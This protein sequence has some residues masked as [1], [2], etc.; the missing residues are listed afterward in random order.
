M[1]FRSLAAPAR[2]FSI[3]VSAAAILLSRDLPMCAQSQGQHVVPTST[4][5]LPAAIQTKLDN[6]GAALKTAQAGGDAKAEAAALNGIG[7]VYFNISEFDKALD[8]Y[9][10]ALTQARAVKDPIQEAAALNGIAGCYRLQNQIA[11]SVQT[12]TEVLNVTKASRDW[13]GQNTAFDGIGWLDI[14]I[15][16]WK[17]ALQTF[18]KNVEL[19]RG[20]GEKELEASAL[21][22]VGIASASLGSLQ[23]A[24]QNAELSIELY[25]DIGDAEG[26]ANGYFALATGYEKL[27][28]H[29]KALQLGNLALASFRES[30]DRRRQCAVL[31][32]LAVIYMGLFQPPK[33]LESLNQA[34]SIAREDGDRA[35]EIMAL[36]GL[37]MLSSATGENKKA[38]ELYTQSLAIARTLGNE[39]SEAN[40]LNLVGNAYETIA[41][42]QKALDNFN[43]AL[44]LYKHQ[45]DLTGEANV[46][47]NIANAYGVLGEPEKSLD[48]YNQAS[49]LF[50]QLN[51]SAGVALVLQ[52]IGWVHM[53][54][55][56]NAKALDNFTRALALFRAQESKYRMT[57][58]L[59]N[60][61]FAHG[62]LNE[63]EKALQPLNEALDLEKELGDRSTEPYTL[64][65]L[66][67][68]YAALGERQKAL[69]ALNQ[70]LPMGRHADQIDTEV[71]TLDKIGAVYNDMGQTAKAQEYL[72]EALP[73]AAEGGNP[74]LQS[75]VL[76]DLML[77]LEKTQPAMAIFYGKLG[78]NQL[79]KMRSS[80][81]GLDKG[82]QGSF[83]VSREDCYHDLADLLIAQGRLPEAQQVLNLLKEQ[84][85]SDYT[86]GDAAN[87]LSPLSLTPAEKQAEDD[88]QKSTERIVGLGEE[89][90]DLRKIT[91]RTPEQD[92]RYKVVSAQI[93]TANASLSD[94][95]NNRLYKLFSA[96]GDANK[97][98]ADVKGQV[99][100]LNQAL[101]KM[102]H[103]VA[104]YTLV[105]KDRTSIIVITR[106]TEVARESVITEA[107][108]NKRIAAFEQVLRKPSSDPKPAAQELYDILIGPV[109]KDLDQAHAETLVWS[110]DGALRYV[111]MAALYDGQHYLVE[112][113]NTVTI[114]PVSIPHLT[115]KPDVS[116]LSVAAMGISRKYEANLPELKAVVGELDDVANDPQVNGAKGALPGTILLDNRFTEQAMEDQLG[117]QP[118][119]VH[120][121]SHFVFNPGDD[122]QSYLLL[123][124]K[125][126]S[127]KGFHL[128]VADFHNKP[129]LTLKGTE[130]LT[131][132]ACETGMSGTTSDGREVDG[133]GTTA[134]SKGAKAVIST[135]WEVDDAST[136]ELMADFY[137]RWAGGG[138][139][140]E[141]VEALRQAQLDLLLGRADLKATE[142]QDT[143]NRGLAPDVPNEPGPQGFAH[144]Y[145]WAPFVLMGNWR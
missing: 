79:Q 89:W 130:L 8:N 39:E 132:S 16:D 98:L 114:T 52:N 108:L 12:Y 99:D 72:K 77:S 82:L 137:R 138:G 55:G 36:N 95:Y 14:D 20:Q 49:P 122:K 42:G 2:I 131:L 92:A 100:D 113:Y 28:M 111:P 22:G 66:G 3:A 57:N 83:V 54:L 21:L 139:K 47:N 133:L 15:A 7:S 67:Y 121:A 80:I 105:G 136:G 144:P 117:S 127:G 44:T 118:T 18:Q 128:T 123:A 74:L 65:V 102:P 26:E 5:P 70:A 71:F 140:V 87:T 9:N 104:L 125:D 31:G 27:R 119:V 142:H 93:E 50:Q 86:R 6:F 97:Q 141:K 84:E 69:D 58:V 51:D 61:G 96:S 75:M 33:A 135:L 25:H 46:L 23:D 24:K 40:G 145:Y 68:A 101:L 115:D 110:L 10:Q 124:D 11:K 107:D 81:Q 116:N 73:K 91:Q 19:T 29:D 112:Q 90:S 94:Y 120:I 62:R 32:G 35:D 56:D 17:N 126:E 134:L 85:Y 48:F 59:T 37:G 41:E 64:T 143:S 63:W 106:S 1:Q 4:P 43:E 88:Y 38:L 109:K 129:N 34:L 76:N 30:G 53:V 45:G 103:T 60:V 78:I 13:F